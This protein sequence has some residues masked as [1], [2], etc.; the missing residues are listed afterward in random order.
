VAVEYRTVEV[1]IL[2]FGIKY[3]AAAVKM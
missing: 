2:A 1:E 3:C